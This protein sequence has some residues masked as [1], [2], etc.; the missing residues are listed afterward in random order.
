MESANPQAEEAVRED[1]SAAQP[2]RTYN[3]FDQEKGLHVPSGS[4]TGE[5]N[6]TTISSVSG[7]A[8]ALIRL[9]RPVKFVVAGVQ[10]VH[11]LR[12][13]FKPWTPVGEADTRT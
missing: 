3:P 2:E 12:C 9:T 11:D 7:N 4:G 5:G 10:L 13:V 6:G 1:S 8:V